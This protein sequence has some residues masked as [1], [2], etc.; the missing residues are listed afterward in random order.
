M[1]LLRIKKKFGLSDSKAV[2]CVSTVF[3]ITIVNNEKE[4]TDVANSAFANSLS[5]V[6][7][8]YLTLTHYSVRVFYYHNY[9]NQK[10]FLLH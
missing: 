2:K 8:I 6:A 9:I 3:M 4:L 7:C 1:V 10:T 5:F